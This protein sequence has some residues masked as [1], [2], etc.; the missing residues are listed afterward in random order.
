MYAVCNAYGDGNAGDCA[1]L[2]PSRPAM[3][4]RGAAG[5][6]DGGRQQPGWAR[7]P[8]AKRRR[9]PGKTSG[10]RGVSISAND[11]YKASWRARIRFGTH[12]INLG[13]FGNETAAAIAYDRAAKLLLGPA[14]SLNFTETPDDPC[15]MMHTAILL[16]HALGGPDN[17]PESV[18]AVAHGEGVPPEIAAAVLANKHAC[19]RFDARTIL[20]IQHQWQQEQQVLEWQQGPAGGDGRRLHQGG[21]SMSIAERELIR[22]FDAEQAQQLPEKQERELLQSVAPHSYHP[23]Y[24]HLAGRP[25]DAAGGAPPLFGEPSGNSLGQHAELC[26]GPSHRQAPLLQHAAHHGGWPP[27]LAAAAAAPA[28]LGERPLGGEDVYASPETLLQGTG[29]DGPHKSEKL[30][31]SDLLLLEAAVAVADAGMVTASLFGPTA[32]RQGGSGGD[33]GT[34]SHSSMQLPPSPPSASVA[35]RRAAKSHFQEGR[36]ACTTTGVAWGRAGSLSNPPPSGGNPLPPPA[37]G[38]GP[39]AGDGPALPAPG[40]AEAALFYQLWEQECLHA[41]SRALH[42]SV[43]SPGP[44][45][46]SPSGVPRAGLPPLPPGMQPPARARAVTGPA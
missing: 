19:Q 22:Q 18:A 41:A 4:P 26:L 46:V 9:T 30:K 8:P 1:T 44:G 35:A 21:P 38:A 3:R 34:V 28:V 45:S 43:Y 23:L 6:A 24:P 39:R 16:A 37:G 10:Y 17:A 20:A 33:R 25:E 11:G 5:G 13:R 42:A 29:E 31:F 40:T 32:A 27:A 2:G 36:E 14:A 7:G 15:A 12:A